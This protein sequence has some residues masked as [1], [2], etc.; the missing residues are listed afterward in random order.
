MKLCASNHAIKCGKRGTLADHGANGGMPGNDDKVTFRQ[1]KSVDVTGIDNHELSSLPMVDAT[2]KTLNDK[3]EVTLTLRNYAHRGANRTLHSSGQIEWCQNRVCDGSIKAGGRQVTVTRDGYCA[4]INI[5]R[6]LPCIQMEPNTADE[7]DKLPHVVLTQGGEWDPSALDHIL[8]HDKDW[9]NKVKREGDP[10]C[11]SPFNLRGECKHREPPA[12]GNT[13]NSPAGPPNEDPDDI[14]VNFHKVDATR[15]ICEAHHQVANLN[16]IHACKGEGM[17]DD[18][19]SDK[20]TDVLDDDKEDGIKAYPPTETESK[21]IDCSKC[22]AQFFHVPIKNVRRTFQATT[23]HAAHVVSGGRIQQ[24]LKSPNPALNVPQ[25]NEPVATD[26]VFADVAAVDTPG[27]TCAQTFV[28]R[29]S[30]LA[31]A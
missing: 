8:T 20:H 19:E 3:G 23:Q 17:P 25:R 29:S 2:A 1:N 7:F 27:Y 15:E 16:Q 14:E 13:I 26:T 4:P 24:T 31:D 6:G 21:P 30:L 9:A 11:E 10:V 12:I 22:R 5:I 18:D 28:G